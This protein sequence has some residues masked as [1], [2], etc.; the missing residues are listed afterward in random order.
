MGHGVAAMSAPP[1]APQRPAAAAFLRGVT[2]AWRSVFAYVLLGT[3]I[4]IGAL[5]HEFG[6]S[7]TWMV[8]STVLIWAAPAQVILISTLPTASLI[9]VAIAVALSSIRFLPMVVAVLPMLRAAQTRQRHLILPAHLTAISVWVEAMRLLPG[10]PRDERIAFYNGLGVGL[11][12]S[13]ITASALGFY[14][15]ARLPPLFAAALLFLTPLALVM[16]VSRNSR[17]LIDRVAFGA[18]IVI[19]PVLAGMKVGLDLLWTGIIAGT[20][21]YLVHRLREAWE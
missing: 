19:G 9:E 8:L 10:V 15:A 5:A 13:A 12:A 4:G 6:F 3:Y 17:E 1:D 11:I 7:L 21:A 20:I 18:G 2:A 14:L 16:S